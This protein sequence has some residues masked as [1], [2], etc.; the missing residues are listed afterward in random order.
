MLNSTDRALPRTRARG[1]GPPDGPPVHRRL[2]ALVAAHAPRDGRFALPVPGTYALRLS[3]VGGEPTR[4]TIQPMLCIVAQGAKVAMLGRQVFEYDASRMLVFAVDLPVAAEVT[5]A[6]QA[7]PYLCFR[8]DL[9]PFRI[10]ELA[11]RVF[12]NGVP[13]TPDLRGLYVAD[14]NNQ[15][16]DAASRLLALSADPAEAEL[17]GPLVVDEILIRLLR[18]S[19]GPRVAQIGHIDSG[20]RRIARAVAEIRSNFAQPLKVEALARLVHMSVSSFHQHFKAVTSM[21]PLQ[22]QKALRLQEARRL[23]LVQPLDA[24]RTAREVGYLSPSQFSRE[25]ARYFGSA[26]TRDIARLR[27]QGIPP[28]ALGEAPTPIRRTS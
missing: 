19:V 4:A 26:P 20:V 22:Y 27:Q 9:D 23:M 12:P 2:A 6:S 16:V 13:K 8:L 17:L 5:R 1:A 15:I 11:L 3:R 10:A 28:P 14:V 21:S 18:S 7:E 24:Q 25:Y